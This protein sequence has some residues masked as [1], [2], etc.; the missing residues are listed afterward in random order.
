MEWGAD[1]LIRHACI[2]SW[3]YAHIIESVIEILSICQKLPTNLDIICIYLALYELKIALWVI[4]VIGWGDIWG[5]LCK[6]IKKK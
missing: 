4:E 6:Y 2:R 3:S 5:W 1:F